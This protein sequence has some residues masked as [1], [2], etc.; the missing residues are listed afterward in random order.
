MPILYIVDD[1][2]ERYC[3]SVLSTSKTIGISWSLASKTSGVILLSMTE[4]RITNIAAINL[5][6]HI[7]G[8]IYISSAFAIA[9]C[10]GTSCRIYS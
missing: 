9:D 6:P 7:Y 3:Q 1:A 5:S 8:N 2:V 10:C 4:N